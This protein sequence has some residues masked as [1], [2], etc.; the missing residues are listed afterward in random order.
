VPEAGTDDASGP[1]GPDGAAGA[2]REIVL[3]HRPKYDDWSL[4]KGKLLPGEDD[5]TAALR[6][7]EEE[8]GLRCEIDRPLGSIEYRDQ[9]GRHKTVA[10][11]L[12]HARS[13]EFTATD[14]VD[15]LLWLGPGE[16]AER[17]SYEHDRDL[18][19]RIDAEPGS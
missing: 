1:D 3:V 12:M 2:G 15:R 6:E 8:T 16:A 5:R 13:G 7:V 11:F 17:L 19:D 4:P 9:L 14:E 18:L 10:Y